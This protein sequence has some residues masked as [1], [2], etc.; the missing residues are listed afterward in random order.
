MYYSI[1]QAGQ[2]HAKKALFI[3]S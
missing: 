3:I 1:V 2:K